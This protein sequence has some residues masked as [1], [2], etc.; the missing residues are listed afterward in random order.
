MLIRVSKVIDYSASKRMNH[1]LIFVLLAIYPYVLLG[2][3]AEMADLSSFALEMVFYPFSLV[4]HLKMVHH[5]VCL[6]GTW[7][8][9]SIHR[10]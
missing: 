4:L 3:G 2:F 7:P 10:L 9:Q 5:E 1:Y 6:K 8:F